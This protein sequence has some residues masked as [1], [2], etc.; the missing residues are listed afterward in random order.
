MNSKFNNELDQNLISQQQNCINYPESLEKEKRVKCKAFEKLSSIKG[1]LY[2]LLYTLLDCISYIL[3]KMAP[4]LNGF[5]HGVSRY[6]TQTIVMTYFLYK[7]DLKLFGHRGLEGI[8]CLRGLTGSV[9]LIF[10]YISLQYLDVSDTQ[11]L[12]NSCVIIT[13][14]LGRIFLKEK[15]T[16]VHVFSVFLTITGV[17]F[18]LRPTFLFGIEE[19]LEEIFHVNITAHNLNVTHRTLEEIN[20]SYSQIIG[21]CLVL[22]N[23]F[24]LSISQVTTRSLSLSKIHHSVISTYANFFGLPINL[25]GSSLFFAM[26]YKEFS[27]MTINSLH[28]VYSLSA[29]L[30]GTIG[31]ICL[32]KA[33]QHEHAAKIGMLRITGILF[34]MIFQYI[35]LDIEIDFLGVIGAICVVLGTILIILIKLYSEPILDSERC[36][37][38]LAVEF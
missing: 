35:L 7:Y 12:I 32:N 1:Y 33:L 8:L 21:V 3:I 29:G 13:A 5:N 37:R 14:L 18:I 9:A 6:L 11:T 28:L 26:N 30:V 25:I 31:L 10:G 23:A 20:E 22:A 34:S 38:F 4:S 19:N 16:I 17:L 15:I 24:C 27:S 2:G 36:Y